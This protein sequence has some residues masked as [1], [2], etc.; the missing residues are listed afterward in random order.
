M[1]E[2]TKKAEQKEQEAKASALRERDLDEVAGGGTD[3]DEIDVVVKKRPYGSG[4][5]SKKS[6]GGSGLSTA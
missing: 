4:G 5:L 6:P 2:Q 1:S 3:V